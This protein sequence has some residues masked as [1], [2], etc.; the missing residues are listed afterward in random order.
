MYVG[1]CR[2]RGRIGVRRPQK[3][4]TK[5]S[6]PLTWAVGAVV[7][8]FVITAA[9]L[10]FYGQAI[11]N[12]WALHNEPEPKSDLLSGRVERLAETP[13][14]TPRRRAPSRRKAPPPERTR[15]TVLREEALP[16][17]KRTFTKTVLAE[18]LVSPDSMAI[19][20]LT[21]KIYVSEEDAWAISVL[22]ETGVRRVVDRD[23]VIVRMDHGQRRLRREPLRFPEGIDFSPEG[24][25]Y[26]VEDIPGGDLIRFRMD[27]R[28]EYPEGEVVDIPGVWSTYAWEGLAIGP[29]GEILMAGSDI[30][31]VVS[32]D[33]I[34]VFAGTILYRDRKGAWWIPHRRYFASY[35]DVQF[36]K[37]GGQA[38]YTCEVTGEIGWLDITSRQTLGGHSD[39]VGRS[40]EGV[41]VLPDGSFLVAEE[42]GD[43]LHIDPASGEYERII[44]GL[45]DIE[46]VLWDPHHERLLV[47]EDGTGRLLAFT[48]DR[49]YDHRV[50]RMLYATYYPAFS[51]QNIPREC[52]EYLARILALGGLRFD[53]PDRAP[54]SFRQF[55]SR[56]PLVAADVNAVSMNPDREI[57]DPVE[58]VQFVI[59]EPNRMTRPTEGISGQ[60]LALFAVRKR[61]GALITTSALPV[62]MLSAEAPISVLTDHGLGVLAVPAASAVSVSGIGVAAVQFM[63]MGRTPDYSLV[64]NPRNPADSYMVVFHADGTRDHYRLNT[65]G[66]SVQDDWVIAYTHVRNAEWTRLSY[67]PD[68][69][70]HEAETFD[71]TQMEPL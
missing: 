60:A 22:T 6:R 19:H 44:T 58:R 29:H 18:G 64:L 43:I 40:P 55:V 2:Q 63:G 1:R 27:A 14:V 53:L 69:T 47:T 12:R 51:Q 28:G 37:N 26:A 8:S 17:I 54:I 9:I 31:Y 42:V 11:G 70:Y 34:G 46:S 56:I 57:D 23:T 7:C 66:S 5:W 35:S 67:G 13:Q 39:V 3:R 32:Q 30:E 71:L 33:T 16:P 25:L 36:S 10:I 4:K 65:V 20:P 48:P 68:E 21:G 52:P 49:G 45:S 24:D 50:D 38:L 59:F 41:G 61:S 15:S 62:Q